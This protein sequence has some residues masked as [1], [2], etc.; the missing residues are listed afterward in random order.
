MQFL[1]TILFAAA[2]SAA[3]IAPRA[4]WAEGPYA[5][6]I[7]SNDPAYNRKWLTTTDFSNG[8]SIG[9]FGAKPAQVFYYAERTGQFL[10]APAKSTASQAD[11]FAAWSYDVAKRTEEATGVSPIYMTKVLKGE[12]RLNEKFHTYV[13]FDLNNNFLQSRGKDDLFYACPSQ[14]EN[15]TPALTILNGEK[16]AEGCSAIKLKIASFWINA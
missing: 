6:Q 10:T 8:V 13:V 11:T 2:A 5:I 3:A 7:T 15:K 12:E 14:T 1:T 9:T 16:A 4:G